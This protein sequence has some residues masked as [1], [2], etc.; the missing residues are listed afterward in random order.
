MSKDSSDPIERRLFQSGLDLSDPNI[1]G[2]LLEQY[3]LFVETSES[4]VS[5]RLTANSFFFSLASALFGAIGVV[6]HQSSSTS[7]VLWLSL[8]LIGL[9]GALVCMAWARLIRSYGQLNAGKFKVIDLLEERLPAALFRAEWLALG[10]GKDPKRYKSFVTSEL[11]IPNLLLV[12]FLLICLTSALQV[13]LSG[14]L[15]LG[16]ICPRA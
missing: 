3:K 6:F 14:K 16:I 11:W 12:V 8:L 9:I 1:A 4:L 5:R 2:M 7:V 10:E 13:V 15:G